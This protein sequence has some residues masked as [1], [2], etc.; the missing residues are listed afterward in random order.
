MDKEL[1]YIKLKVDW[2]KSIFP[3]VLAMVVGAATF[4]QSVDPK[5]SMAPLVRPLLILA[6]CFLVGALLTSWYAALA[7]IHR[8][9]PPYKYKTKFLNS[10]L[11]L[12]HGPKSEMV[13][14]TLA[15]ACLGAGLSCFVGA[16]V[17]SR[18]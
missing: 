2:Y 6:V 13:F 12:P 17:V 5:S 9:E 15:G 16:L 18:L 14:A 7:L 8:L 4:A 11:W 10:L 1:E 3:W